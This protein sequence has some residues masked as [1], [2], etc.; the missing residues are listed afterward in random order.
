M[1]MNETSIDSGE[2]PATTRL[3]RTA[4]RARAALVVMSVLL[5]AWVIVGAVTGRGGLP[6]LLGNV[7][8]T[9]LVAAIVAILGG[10]LLD[11]TR[12]KNVAWRS[13]RERFGAGFSDRPDRSTFGT[14]RGLVGEHA[15]YGLRCFGCA[16][17]LEVGRILYFLNPPIFIPWSAMAKIDTFPN[18]LTG[19]KDFETDEQARIHLRD[20]SDLT[21]EVPWLKEYRQLLPKTV[22]YRAIKLSKK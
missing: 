18:I 12:Q 14:G 15:Y 9:V 1:T 20:P 7:R 2:R 17:G 6:W 16:D 21:L 3:D 4:L 13:L 19:R 11:A 8:L 5:I 10:M 22:K